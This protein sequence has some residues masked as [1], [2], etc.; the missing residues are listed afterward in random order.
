MYMAKTNIL[1]EIISSNSSKN[2]YIKRFKKS[3][4][5]TPNIAPLKNWSY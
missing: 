1:T 5:V 2:G 4:K 3:Q